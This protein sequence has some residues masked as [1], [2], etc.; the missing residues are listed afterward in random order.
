[1]NLCTGLP[2]GRGDGGGSIGKAGI[3]SGEDGLIES[4]PALA[5]T[6]VASDEFFSSSLLSVF[7]VEK[8]SSEDS[9]LVTPSFSRDR[10][11]SNKL[12]VW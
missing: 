9:E 7:G 3:T 12:M 5:E 1:M 10:R 4:V 2:S 11:R 8:W 6:P